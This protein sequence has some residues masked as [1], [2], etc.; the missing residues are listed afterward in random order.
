MLV[1]VTLTALWGFGFVK[2]GFFPTTNS[3]LFFVDIRLPQGTDVTA[4]AAE[5]ERLEPLVSGDPDVVSVTSF[6]GQGPTR[7]AATVRPE[8]P[9]P[10]YAQLVVGVRDVTGIGAAMTRVGAALRDASIDAEIGVRRTEFTL[11][12]TSKI[13]ARF[14]GSDA[15]VLRALAD[16][17]LDIYLDH[18]L[19]DRKT[20]WRQ[21]EITL[22]PH[23]D[24][25]RARQA[26]VSRNDVATALAI[27]G[28]GVRI[29]IFRDA[30]KLIPIIV[31]APERER[32]DVRGLADRQVWSQTQQ[33]YVPLGQVITGLDLAA[34]DSIIMHRERARS[35]SAFANPP[36]GH[37]A[38]R[39]FERIRGDI[40]RI[41]LP[42]GYRLEWG[43]EFEASGQANE[44]LISKVPM[45]FGIM[46]LVT[47]L[48]FGKVRQT[49]VI[50]LIVPMAICGVVVSLLITDMAFTF[51]SLL[52]FLSLSGMLIKNAI[53]LVDEIDKRLAEG[54]WTL[55][56]VAQAS[57]SRVR[58]VML[59]AGTTVAGM[60][61]LLNDAFFREM[62]VSIMGGLTFA[63][64]LTLLA[65]PVLYRAFMGR[66]LQG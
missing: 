58:P 32:R 2:Q 42:P 46:V 12:G 60:A 31:R 15:T 56:T 57:V 43:G 45:A 62:A 14:S 8:Q 22:E 6:I 27:A 34:E 5:I 13:E 25:V 66:R 65:V 28:S 52:G 49:L 17:A 23:F 26:G 24:E 37:N 16:Q 38:T 19:I 64:L 44:A 63:T 29:G 35:I 1:A 7:F 47:I 41:A 40:E 3:P 20:D 48:M 10:A 30:D 36:A 21:R 53:V 50:W 4:T 33:A 11:G 9:N 54:E 39:T 55:E 18:D 61:P 51:P 59:A